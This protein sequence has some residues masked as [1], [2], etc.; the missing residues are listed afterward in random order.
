[1]I[2]QSKLLSAYDDL[3]YEEKIKK[4]KAML[5]ILKEEGNIFSDLYEILEIWEGI[6]ETFVDTIYQIITK[7]MYSLHTEELD[8]AVDKLEQAK[9]KINR[10]KEKEKQEEGNPDDLLDNI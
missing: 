7:A 3:S 1:M 5:S 8:L 2:P 10:M 9:N 4:V 6:S